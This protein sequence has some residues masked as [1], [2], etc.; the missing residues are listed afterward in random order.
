VQN[1]IFNFFDILDNYITFVPVKNLMD[2]ISSYLGL[3]IHIKN[4]FLTR[5]QLKYDCPEKDERKPLST[6]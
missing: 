3:I 5:W 4:K 1:L 2:D 6:T